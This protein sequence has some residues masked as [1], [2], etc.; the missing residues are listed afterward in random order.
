MEIRRSAEII[1]ELVARS[2]VMHN[3]YGAGKIMNYDDDHGIMTVL[4]DMT[5]DNTNVRD[6]HWRN[7]ELETPNYNK[8]W[9]TVNE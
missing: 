6:I 3:M 9:Q 1:D 4:F 5:T 8:F 2:R 7:L